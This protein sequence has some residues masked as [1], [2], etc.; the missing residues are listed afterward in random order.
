MRTPTIG[1]SLLTIIE[2]RKNI[3]EIIYNIGK[4][5]NKE[6]ESFLGYEV[7]FESIN[8]IEDLDIYTEDFKQNIAN[9]I[10]Q[11]EEE[12]EEELEMLEQIKK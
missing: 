2:F 12:D 3:Y 1:K 5:Y 11:H 9:L 6:D 4:K 7:Y 10:L 8:S